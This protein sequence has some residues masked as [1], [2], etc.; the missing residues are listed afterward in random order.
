LAAGNLGRYHGLTTLCKFRQ[1]L[2]S[3]ILQHP[4]NTHTHQTA[5]G[6]AVALGLAIFS[7]GGIGT[8]QEVEKDRSRAGVRSGGSREAAAP[9]IGEGEKPA[10]RE[11]EGGNKSAAREGERKPGAGDGEGERKPGMREGEGGK[12]GGDAEG[13]KRGPRDGEGAAKKGPRD[14][15]AAGEAES[16]VLRVIDGGEKVQ[17]GK[18]RINRQNLRAHLSQFLPEHPGAK[19][20]VEAED[21]V[22]FKIVSEVLDAARDNGAKKATIQSAVKDQ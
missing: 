20:T 19:V 15:D 12:R 18:E 11:A 4:M 8:A 13:A 5:A 1:E 2:P 22:P 3:V 9:R 17:I 16:I 14:G 6:V 7:A 21:D 10:M